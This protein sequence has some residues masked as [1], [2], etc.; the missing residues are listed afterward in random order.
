MG[1]YLFS[2]HFNTSGTVGNGEGA[3]TEELPLDASHKVAAG[4]S[5]ARLRRS[6]A[7]I[8]VGTTAGASD[9][10]RM[11]TLQS[12]ARI[13][14]VLWDTDGGSTNGTADL[15]FYLSGAAHDGALPSTNSV[16]AFSSSAFDIKT[17]TAAASG[18]SATRVE[19][20]ELGDYNYGDHMGKEIWELI[21]ITDASTYTVNPIVNY[22][23]TFTI[24]EAVSAAVVTVQLEV[25]YTVG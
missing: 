15:G 18:T 4:L 14:S 7:R 8:T 6:H 19:A 9:Q 13:Y 12:N 21:N 2:N 5:H 17:A 24:V 11:L 25:L 10:L 3:L 20:F 23:L 22:D 16:D 1:I